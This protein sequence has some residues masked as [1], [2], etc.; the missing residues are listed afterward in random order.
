MKLQWERDMEEGVAILFLQWPS[1]MASKKFSDSDSNVEASMFTTRSY[2]HQNKNVKT[3]SLV[4]I[5]QPNTAFHRKKRNRPSKLPCITWSL[6][7]QK[8]ED[9]EIL[10]SISSVQSNS[11]AFLWIEV[12]PFGVNFG[13]IC[14][15]MFYKKYLTDST[16]GRT[17]D[18]NEN[19]LSHGVQP[20]PCKYG[21]LKRP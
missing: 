5:T 11:S 8:R 2:Y 4:T 20:C 15:G 3:A 14:Q 13:R 9:T 10:L 19:S 1:K 6:P 18:Y 17:Q 21:S 7:L 12:P 16:M